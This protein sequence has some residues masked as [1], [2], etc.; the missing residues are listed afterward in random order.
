MLLASSS[1]EAISAIRY[2]HI[3]AGFS[4]PL[5][6]R[7][8]LWA[9]LQGLARWESAPIRKVPVTPSMLGGT[10]DT[11]SREVG[12]DKKG[13]PFG[14]PSAPDGS[15]CLELRSISPPLLPFMLHGGCCEV[16][17][18][19]ST[20][21]VCCLAFGTPMRFLFSDGKLRMSNFSE[22]KRVHT[23]AQGQKFARLRPYR[24]VLCKT[25][26]GLLTRLALFSSVKV[27][28]LLESKSPTFLGW[29]AP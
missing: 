18:F 19:C 12:H 9:S 24:T 21:M 5:Q 14:G 7:V 26:F 23:T 29:P 28:G 13:K 22:G 16:V 27:W 3:A 10:S 15:L 4:D 25:P 1:A 11:C 2:A 17:T 8:R 6:G 20:K